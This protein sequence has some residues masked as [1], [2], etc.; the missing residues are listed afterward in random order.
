[1]DAIKRW[2]RS[3]TFIGTNHF[4]SIMDAI[5]LH[6]MPLQQSPT[7][8]FNSIMDA[9][10]P[11]RIHRVAYVLKISTPL[12]MQSNCLFNRFFRTKFIFQLHYGCNQT[13]SPS[14][15][16]PSSRISTP[17]WMQSNDDVPLVLFIIINYFNSIM[18]AIKQVKDIEELSDEPEF[19]LHYG[20]N[21]T[22]STNPIISTFSPYKMDQK[23]CNS[24]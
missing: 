10:K 3:I 18:D 20:C 2:R 23:I 7:T 9:I 16:L 11:W 24:L 19:Q 17:L 14:S 4:N 21:Q 1:M 6:R 22:L 8:D 13:H 15:E 12:W 5:K